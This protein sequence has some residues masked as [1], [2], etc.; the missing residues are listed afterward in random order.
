LLAGI[1]QQHTRQ[2]RSFCVTASL[3]VV[4]MAALMFFCWY[5]TMGQ[6]YHNA[7]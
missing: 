1:H 3:T 6:L 2:A 4:L 5:Y 7:V